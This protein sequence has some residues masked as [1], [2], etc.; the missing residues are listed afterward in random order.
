MN[1]SK[2][3]SLFDRLALTP[4]QTE[5]VKALQIIEPGIID[6]N[7]LKDDRRRDRMT[8]DD[9][10]APY[11]A[12]EGEVKPRRLSSMGD[13]I[14]RVLT[15]ILAMLNARDGILLIDEFENGLHYSV[16]Q[17]LW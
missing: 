1:I 10:R 7:F 9:E 8:R 16:Q 6:L 11:I 15:I 5:V 17:K 13:G 4:L 14:N 3:P 2:N 12:L